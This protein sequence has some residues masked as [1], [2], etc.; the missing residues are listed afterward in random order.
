MAQLV[1][2]TISMLQCLT[3]IKYRNLQPIDTEFTT[4]DMMRSMIGWINSITK[5][6]VPLLRNMYEHTRMVRTDECDEL[7]STMNKFYLM[8]DSMKGYESKKSSTM[9]LIWKCRPASYEKYVAVI[10]A[11]DERWYHSMSDWVMDFYT[12]WCY[13]WIDD[14]AKYYRTDENS[15]IPES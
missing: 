11:L 14:W 6:D 3:P 15:H 5:H 10:E 13:L 2:G 4:P 7:I 1:K 8:L 12:N 9:P